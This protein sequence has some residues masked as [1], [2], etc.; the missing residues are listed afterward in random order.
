MRARPGPDRIAG[1]EPIPQI[2]THTLAN[3]SSP[4][5]RGR[6]SA[7]RRLLLLNPQGHGH[8]IFV[9]IFTHDPLLPRAVLALCTGIY[10]TSF[11]LFS[12]LS[13]TSLS[14]CFSLHISLSFSLSLSI[15]PTILVPHTI[16]LT[17]CSSYSTL[18]LCLF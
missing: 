1:W 4:F 12:F 10:L 5:A 6:D 16:L 18:S 14:L 15:L 7:A 13:V 11:S 9:S 2:P 17:V 3:S 8:V